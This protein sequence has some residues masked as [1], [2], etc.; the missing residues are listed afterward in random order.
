VAAEIV[1]VGDLCYE[2]TLSERLLAWLRHLALT[3]RVI[4]AEP[5]RAFAPRAGFRTLATYVVPTLFDLENKTERTVVL[6]EI[7]P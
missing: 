3:R 4:L 1:I 2:R 5:G 6:L 7:E